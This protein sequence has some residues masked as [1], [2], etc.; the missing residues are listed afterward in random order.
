MVFEA[1][2]KSTGPSPKKT[3]WFKRRRDNC[4]RRHMYDKTAYYDLDVDGKAFEK[5]LS[6]RRLT[7][8]EMIVVVG[9]V[10]LG[11][12]VLR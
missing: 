3:L 11:L 9:L 5:A 7:L 6:R 2:A 4:E 8:G 12:R 10:H 1:S